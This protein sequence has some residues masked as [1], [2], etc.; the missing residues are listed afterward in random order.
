MKEL[1]FTPAQ[2]EGDVS[3]RLLL[4]YLLPILET[5]IDEAEKDLARLSA[6]A[7]DFVTT[8]TR[9]Q[10]RIEALREL[11][12]YIQTTLNRGSQS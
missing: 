9:G 8:Y 3:G 7:P 4:E 1:P 12:S 6:G 2:L 5:S 11:Y 10:G